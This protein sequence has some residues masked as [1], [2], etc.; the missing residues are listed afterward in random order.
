MQKAEQFKKVIFSR[1]ISR[2]PLYSRKKKRE[3]PLYRGWNPNLKH[4][5]SISSQFTKFAAKINLQ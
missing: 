4:A 2:H 3:M 5:I 1:A